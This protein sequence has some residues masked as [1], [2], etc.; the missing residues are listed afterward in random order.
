LASGQLL[1]CGLVVRP[2][3]ERHIRP[4]LS[5][6]KWTKESIPKSNAREKLPCSN[7]NFAAQGTGGGFYA[8]KLNAL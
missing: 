3:G 4:F 2:T 1:L 8:A 5:G 7:Q 6:K